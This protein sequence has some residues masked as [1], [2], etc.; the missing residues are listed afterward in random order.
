MPGL[1]PARRRERL[2]AFKPSSFRGVNNRTGTD[3]ETLADFTSHAGIPLFCLVLEI[4]LVI[5][6][7]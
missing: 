2:P 3:S 6:N 4:M 7:F 5:N 1:H